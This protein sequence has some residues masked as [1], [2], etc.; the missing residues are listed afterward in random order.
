MKQIC[1]REIIVDQ[2]LLMKYWFIS[3][4][5]SHLPAIYRQRHESPPVYHL[6]QTNNSIN[7][8]ITNL[9]AEY[10]LSSCSS[11]QV[12]Y[13][14][15]YGF[16]REIDGIEWLANIALIIDYAKATYKVTEAQ[17]HV[18]VPHVTDTLPV[19]RHESISKLAAS[20]PIRGQFAASCH[21]DVHSVDNG[22]MAEKI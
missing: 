22:D 10:I 3:N 7:L 9:G 11:Y 5:P 4:L 20:D 21:I 16:K 13:A 2:D 1:V 6:H 8:L 18:K 15:H 17:R 19:G 14:S 12:R